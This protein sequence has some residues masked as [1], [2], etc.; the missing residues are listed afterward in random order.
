MTD[1]VPVSEDDWLYRSKI[2]HDELDLDTHVELDKELK[3]KTKINQR[4]ID[5]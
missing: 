4:D 2:P 1:H 3:T 5:R